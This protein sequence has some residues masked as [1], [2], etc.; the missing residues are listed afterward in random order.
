MRLCARQGAYPV[1]EHPFIGFGRK[2]GPGTPSSDDTEPPEDAP[3][4]EADERDDD[5]S[6]SR[7]RHHQ[8]YALAAAHRDP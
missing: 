7:V 4:W 6:A 1:P 8:T 5:A 3:S 2:V